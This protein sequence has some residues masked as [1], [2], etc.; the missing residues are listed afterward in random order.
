V[1]SP[2]QKPIQIALQ[3]KKVMSKERLKV[4]NVKSFSSAGYKPKNT[5]LNL[6]L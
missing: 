1:Q 3:K 5:V 6:W 2:I 4:N